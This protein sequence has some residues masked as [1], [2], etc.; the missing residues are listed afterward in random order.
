MKIDE[1]EW[2]YKMVDKVDEG[3][4]RKMKLSEGECWQMKMDVG[5]WR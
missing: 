3:R 2:R 1:G 4:W 5:R